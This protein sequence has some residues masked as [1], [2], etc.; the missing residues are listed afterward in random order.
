MGWDSWRV[1]GSSVYEAQVKANAAAMV[2]NGMAAVGYQYVEPSDSGAVTRNASTGLLWTGDHPGYFPDDL[3]VLG[4]YIHSLGLKFGFYAAPGKVGCNVFPGSQGFETSDANQLAGWGVDRLMYDNCSAFG[5]DPATQ[6]AYQT[7]AMALRATGRPILFLIAD[8]Y[9]LHYAVAGYAPLMTWA[10]NAGANE[11]WSYS[12]EGVGSTS[13]DPPPTVP[14]TGMLLV[15]D[16]QFG[17]TSRPGFFN[18][19]DFLA[20]GN[21]KLTDDEG[22]SNFSLWAIFA[23]PLLAGIDL[24]APPSAATMATLKNT[25]VIAVDQDP[26]GIEGGR[27]SRAAC[28]DAN[29]E[30]YA[31]QLSG[32]KWAVVLFNRASTPQ[33]ITATWSMFSSVGTFNAH[34]DWAH[35]DL[36]P[37]TTGYT[38]T[39]SSHGVAML[40]LSP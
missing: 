6:L 5:K 1:Y 19:P 28:G 39:V 21:G 38:A 34:D 17:L 40:T 12:D 16:G 8:P 11:A 10:A 14:W 32:S 31:R 3:S 25:D 26:L 35:A 2:N 22:R 23:A 36:G 13:N 24:T 37:M 9:D 4:A 30:V 7:M 20:V 18:M 33:S 29:C 15:I 27:V